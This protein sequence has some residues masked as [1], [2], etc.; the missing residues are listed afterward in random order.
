MSEKSHFTVKCRI[1]PTEAQCVQL[2][3][4]F[5][6]C[7]KVYNLMLSDKINHYR[8]CKESLMTTPAQYKDEYPYLREVDSLALA[9][10]QLHLQTAYKNFFSDKR[11]GFPKYKSKKADSNSYTTNVVGN[12]IVVASDSIKLPKVGIVAAKVH[13]KAP[14]GAKLKSVTVSQESDSRYYAAILYEVNAQPV[15]QVPISEDISH[16]GFD[17]KSNGLYV[18]S[19]GESADMPHFFR[20][21]QKKLAKAQRKLAKKASGSKNRE[22]QRKKVAKIASHVANQRKAFLHKR[23]AEITNQYELV[24]VESLNMKSMARSLR[25]GKATHDNGFGMFCDMLCY[26]QHKKGHYFIKVD[27]MFPSSQLCQCGYKNPVTKD[28]KVRIVTCPVC[29]R[30]YDRDINA[31]I[32]LDKE[33]LRSLLAS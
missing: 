11:I 13:R 30:I 12:N 10:E 16:I 5:G 24:S 22:K 14:D 8:E 15:P 27:R 2:A 6:C 17:Y 1:Y 26:K 33:G 19:L 18:N 32:N 31:A 29:G 28:L 7:R 23:S 20:K 25:L 21:A 4:T 3:K 9:N